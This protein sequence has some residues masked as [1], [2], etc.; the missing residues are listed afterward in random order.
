MI[1]KNYRHLRRKNNFAKNDFNKLK[2]ILKLILS[3]L[4]LESLNWSAA[5]SEMSLVPP[6]EAQPSTHDS[7]VLVV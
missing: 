7:Y 6:N 5:S 1:S 3:H 4:I 2:Q